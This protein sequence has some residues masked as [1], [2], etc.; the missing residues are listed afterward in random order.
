MG[1]KSFILK[2][3]DRKITT[4]K[5]MTYLINT[6]KARKKSHFEEE[7]K[8]FRLFYGCLSIFVVIIKIKLLN[9][10]FLQPKLLNT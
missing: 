2:L 1:K 9:N 5:H 3:L 7:I 8:E 4:E 6:I 10:S